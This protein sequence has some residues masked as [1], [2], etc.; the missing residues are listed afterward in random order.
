MQQLLQIF[1]NLNQHNVHTFRTDESNRFPKQ[2]KGEHEPPYPP[3][4]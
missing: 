2:I 1:R 4:N 3:Q